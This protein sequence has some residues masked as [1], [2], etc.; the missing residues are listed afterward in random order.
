MFPINRILEG[1]CTRLLKR[2]P[3]GCVDLI[4]TDPPYGVRYQDGFGRTIAN[5][6]DPSRVLGAFTHLY[7]VLKRD[8]LCISFYGWSQVDAFFCAWRDAGFRPVGHI[9]WVK[10]YASR[11][12]DL[13]YRH[14]QAYVLA[15]GRPALSAEPLDDIQPWTYTGNADH[16]TQKSEEIL[17]PLIE[18]FTL[19]GQVVLDSFAGCGSTLV[20]AAMTGRRYLGI[21][22]DQ[23]YCAAARNRL[24]RVVRQCS[25][26]TTRDDGAADLDCDFQ[27]ADWDGLI[28][29]FD[30]RGHYD[31]ANV[32]RSVKSLAKLAVSAVLECRRRS[33]DGLL[34]ARK[35]LRPIAGHCTATRSVE[36]NQAR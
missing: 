30:E 9:V 29:W 24:A 1:D 25:R 12:R 28:Q 23:Q 5:D 34:M 11:T 20:A 21:E 14:E 10:E 26:L 13:R 36:S 17:I 15:K 22:L 27:T 2:L 6:D 8:S 4:V 18:A 16:P 3:D 32:V 31:L 33:P 35:A 7:R 19:P